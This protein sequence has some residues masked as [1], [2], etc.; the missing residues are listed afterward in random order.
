LASAIRHIFAHG[1]LSP[2]AN[3][4]NPNTVV[5]IC[6][7]LHQFLLSF[8]DIEFSNRLDKALKEFT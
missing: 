5:E 8:M 7:L 6:D 3:Q 1:W 4:V 2:N